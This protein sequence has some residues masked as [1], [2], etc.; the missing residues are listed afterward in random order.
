M[1]FLFNSRGKNIANVEMGRLHSLAGKNI[2]SYL[3]AEGIFI[4]QRGK[5]LGEV[6]LGNRLMSNPLSPHRGTSFAVPGQYGSAGGLGSP[7]PA[8]DVA[9]VVGYTDIR[10]VRLK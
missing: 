9:P 3:N 7:R 5:Y 6:V 2:G 10:A 4:D 1:Q 8:R